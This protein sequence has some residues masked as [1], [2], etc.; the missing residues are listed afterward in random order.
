[1][2]LDMVMVW[3]GPILQAFFEKV[4]ENLFELSG[5]FDAPVEEVVAV[6]SRASPTMVNSGISDIYMAAI[7]NGVLGFV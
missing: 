4:F 2:S 7:N 3:L 1:M 6:V 5:W